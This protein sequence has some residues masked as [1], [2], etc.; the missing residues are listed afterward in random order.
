MPAQPQA[1]AKTDLE[2]DRA[3]HTIRFKRVFDFRE[4]GGHDLVS[5]QFATRPSLLPILGIL[6]RFGSIFLRERTIRA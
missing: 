2:I 6:R 3:S 5:I 1:G 4:F